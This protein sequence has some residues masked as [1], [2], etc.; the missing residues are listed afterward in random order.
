[1]HAAGSPL[2]DDADMEGCRENAIVRFVAI[3]SRRTDQSQ[4]S[5]VRRVRCV[6]VVSVVLQMAA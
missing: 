3:E 4:S 1:M 5:R 2:F 6:A